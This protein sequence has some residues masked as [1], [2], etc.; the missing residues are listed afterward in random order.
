MQDNTLDHDNS[1]GE[2]YATRD[3]LRRFWRRVEQAEQ[4]ARIAEQRA[5]DAE[6]RLRDILD[7]HENH[8]KERG[9]WPPELGGGQA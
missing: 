6:A 1:S 8:P 2:Q 5:E 9:S 7:A 4:R 3:D